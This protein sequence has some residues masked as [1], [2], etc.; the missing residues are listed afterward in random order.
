MQNE[1]MKQFKGEVHSF[2]SALARK[3]PL[4]DDAQM[5]VGSG[6]SGAELKRSIVHKTIDTEWIDVIENALPYLDLFIRHPYSAIED[7]DEILPV[8]ISRHITEKSI[9]HLAQHTNLIL[10]VEG[11]E[12]TPQKI[13]NV[14]HDET[15][16]TY[17]NKFVNTLINR[18]FAF[19]DKRFAEL[20]GGS[21]V[22]QKYVFKYE[23]KF[24]HYEENDRKNEATVRV[25]IDF[26]TAACAE[27]SESEKELCRIYNERFLR[28]EKI[29][30]ALLGYMSSPFIRSMG[31]S[32]IRPPVIRTNAILKNKNLRACLEL[33]EYIESTVKVGYAISAD[34]F[35]EMPEGSFV[36]D[37]YPTVSWQYAD[38]Y[39]TVLGDLNRRLI[40]KRHLFE[41]YP[42]FA[43]ELEFGEED[44]YTVYDSEY[45]KLVP[46]SRLLSNRKKL[47]EDEKRIRIAL[48]IA[49][50]ADAILEERRRAEEEEAKRLADEEAKRLAEEEAKRLAEEEAKRLAEEEAKR[51]AEEAK[52]LAEEEAARLAAASEDEDIDVTVMMDENGALHIVYARYRKSFTARLIQSDDTVKA[53]YE[54][55]KNELL[56]YKKVKSRM[57]WNNETFKAG[58]IPCAKL[59][60]RGKTLW[61]YLNLNP[62]DYRE[63]KYFFTD[64]SDKS[65][66]R[67]VPFGMKIKSERSKKHASELIADMMA[68]LG[69]VR[70]PR[71]A[72]SYYMPYE[73]NEPLIER[74]LIKVYYSDSIT[75]NSTVMRANIGELFASGAKGTPEEEAKRL[76]EE[77]AKRLAEEE[78]K[79]LAEEEAKRLAEEEA[80]RLAE[81]EAKRLAEEEAAR[82]AA[83][84]EDEDVDVTVMMDENGALHIVYARYR[85]SFTARLIQSDDT[86]KAAYEFI[87]NELLSYKKV[88]SRMSWNNETFKAGRIPCAKLAIRGKTLWLYLNL[89][90]EDYR[91]SKYFFTDFSDKSKYRDVPFGMKIKSERSKK[92]ASELIA[93]MMA[94]L[95]LVRIPREAES[96]YMPYEENEPLIE[97]DLIKVY[98][99]DS[100]TENSTVMRANIGELFASGAKGTSEEEAKR[101]A[102]E[103][104]KLAEKAKRFAQEE[105]KRLAEEEAKR[106]AEEEAKRLAE[107]EAKRLAEEEAKRLA[108]ESRPIT[109]G[110]YTLVFK[111][112]LPTVSDVAE[113]SLGEDKGV[114]KYV[115]APYTRAQYL[116]LPRKK[117][118]RVLTNLR[119]LR[120]REEGSARQGTERS[121]VSGAHWDE[122]R[123]WESSVKRADAE[124]SAP[125]RRRASNLTIEEMVAITK[126]Q[127][128]LEKK[129]QKSDNDDE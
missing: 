129:E 49:L 6:D 102:E 2:F 15:L 3:C 97:R 59:A 75:E 85:K 83:A 88:K 96:Y 92:H 43:K 61:L 46:V 17:E 53:A 11:D 93:D 124:T 78:A 36:S 73:E 77:E 32:Y 13:L 105:T 10:K 68:G 25:H 45:K 23:T 48:L 18:L 65:K 121:D 84:S 26:N 37:F 19:I 113:A 50:E 8:E 109:D 114:T 4:Y 66:Y 16:L 110:D 34:E 70:I 52:R 74:D 54:F 51:L 27:L 39:N 72:E 115:L 122:I 117:K 82:L 108:E 12:I 55:I 71:E 95:G 101:L 69:L 14:Y 40:S 44:D 63:S 98:Y 120:E 91:E 58:R 1:E 41:T 76:A 29:H 112:E 123:R 31:K 87:K 56:S 21:G 127:M 128:L 64:F 94:G 42:D 20:R 90:P 116:A 107:E 38:F 35:R 28:V 89:N 86:V 9:K 103:A 118:K 22:E 5:L 119:K 111:D 81:E 106:L 79:R 60:I 99:S 57:S 100:I 7:V 62:E 30:N 47:S 126:A 80:K 24:T 67:D 125:K 104:A 33:W